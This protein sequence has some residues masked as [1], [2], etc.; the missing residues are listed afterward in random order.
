MLKKIITILILLPIVAFA[1]GS[2]HALK[3]VDVDLHD[4]AAL[5]RGART[6]MNYC[7]GCHSLKFMRYNRLAKDIGIVDEDG[8]V[9]SKLVSDNLIFTDA[10]IVETVHVAM[11]VEAAKSWFGKTPPD[12]SLVAR[13]RGADWI[14]TYLSSFYK[15]PGS[16]WGTNNL[17]FKDVAMPNILADLQGEQI[18]IMR[19][20]TIDFGGTK[21]TIEVIERLQLIKDG[22]MTPHQFDAS[23]QDLTSF[24]VYVGEPVKLVR[25]KMGFWVLFYLFILAGLTYM[26]K[27]EYWKDIK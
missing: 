17:V 13:V 2:E 24:L 21:K 5:Q 27:R 22:R 8:E 23:I 10:G 19:S 1:S 3:H 15:E 20:E 16:P 9:Y 11:P 14:Y 7:A 18:P 6:Y 12:L 25:Y 26:L 4:K